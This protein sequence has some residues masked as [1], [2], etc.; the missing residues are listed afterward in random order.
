MHTGDRTENLVDSLVMLAD[1]NLSIINALFFLSVI[2]I[3]V[4]GLFVTSRLGSVFRA[5]LLTARTASVSRH[6]IKCVQFLTIEYEVEMIL[7]SLMPSA[8]I[9]GHDVEYPQ[10]FFCEAAFCIVCLL[11]LAWQILCL[12]PVLECMADKCLIAEFHLKEGGSYYHFL[13]TSCM[14][15]Q[16]NNHGG[17]YRLF[18]QCADLYLAA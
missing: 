18:K 11:S 5:V 14:H 8:Q 9:A 7:K 2:G 15:S 17:C 16:M 3:N 4:F 10:H 12:Q 13:N 6:L 1:R